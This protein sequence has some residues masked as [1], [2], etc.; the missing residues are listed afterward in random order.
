MKTPFTFADGPM[1]DCRSANGFSIDSSLIGQTPVAG[2]RRFIMRWD[3]TRMRGGPQG[4][5]AG[6]YRF[7]REDDGSVKAYFVD[8]PDTRQF[9]VAE[10]K[11]GA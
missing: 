9:E 11:E 3:R 2:D 1:K 8:G 7:Q 6:L 5:A 4:V 10:T